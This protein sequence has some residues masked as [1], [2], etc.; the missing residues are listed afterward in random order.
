MVQ[1]E[2]ETCYDLYRAAWQYN[3][4][5][6]T[7]KVT[8]RYDNETQKLGFVDPISLEMLGLAMDI[9]FNPLDLP[10][11]L[12]LYW[13]GLG[14]TFL[15]I[16]NNDFSFK[17][18]YELYELAHPD[19]EIAFKDTFKFQGK[20]FQGY[21]YE[22]SFTVENNIYPGLGYRERIKRYF[23]YNNQG[24]LYEFH[25]EF[26]YYENGTGEYEIVREG[27]FRYSIDSYDESLVV[28]YAWFYGISAIF[29]TSIVYVI[30]K[31]RR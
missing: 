26:K 24:I 22:Y 11:Y 14:F 8:Y 10:L 21:H 27:T 13:E 29:V 6:F 4:E 15:P 18:D 30:G 5:T 19:F 28:S 23:S 20:K 31:K 3:N 16:F 2:N 1:C 17:T 9:P 12:F 7:V 25:N